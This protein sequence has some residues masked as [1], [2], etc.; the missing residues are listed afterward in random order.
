M[1][2]GGELIGVVGVQTR[3]LRPYNVGNLG[4]DMSGLGETFPWTSTSKA[5]GSCSD[6][7]R[8][9]FWSAE[10]FVSS[11]VTRLLQRPARSLAPT[12]D[13]LQLII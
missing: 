7:V 13:W 6:C 10:R 3:V 4:I 9:E 12:T 1:S 8:A 5:H 2:S 11:G